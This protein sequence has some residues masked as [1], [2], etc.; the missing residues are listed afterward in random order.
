M[1]GAWDAAPETVYGVGFSGASDAG[2]ATWVAEGY[3]E[4]E[5]LVLSDC[6][7]ATERFGVAPDRERTLPRLARFLADRGWD[8]A[9]GLDA[10]FSLPAAVVAGDEWSRLVYGFPDAFAGPEDFRETCLDRARLLAGESEGGESVRRRRDTEARAGAP[11]PYGRPRHRRTFHA[12]RDVLRPLALADAASILPFRPPSRT[13]P[14]LLETHPPGTLDRLDAHREGYEG[15]TDA[16]RARREANLA[17]VEEA[18]VAFEGGAREAARNDAG[19]DA[20]EGCL[21]AL[22]AFEATRTPED[23]HPGEFD[24]VEGHAYV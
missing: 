18:G 11:C 14:W 3:V 16:G 8:A 9:V 7:P 22:A 13:A 10:P 21:A 2:D 20:L 23:L 4:D 17:A 6:R 24:P 5:T 1:A 15:D 12:I 19:G